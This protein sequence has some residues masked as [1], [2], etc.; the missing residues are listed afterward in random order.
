MNSMLFNSGRSALCHARTVA[1]VGTQVGPTKGRTSERVFA[2]ACDLRRNR[3][4]LIRI[5]PLTRDRRAPA[6]T[7]AARRMP[8]N[9]RVAPI[10][11]IT[12]AGVILLCSSACCRFC[13]DAFAGYVAG[14]STANV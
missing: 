1:S 9:V 3:T 4:S 10:G 2:A 6:A 11:C 5:Y 14:T 7:H 13:A 12:N 8:R